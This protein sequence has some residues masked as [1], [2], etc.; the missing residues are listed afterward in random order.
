VGVITQTKTHSHS[1]FW[2]VLLMIDQY[3]LSVLC[4]LFL[5]RKWIKLKHIYSVLCVFVPIVAP[6]IYHF[7]QKHG[8][9]TPL[10]S[11]FH[12]WCTVQNWSSKLKRQKLGVQNR[13]ALSFELNL[14]MIS[15]VFM[16]LNVLANINAPMITPQTKTLLKIFSNSTL[17]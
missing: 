17:I 8:V 5:L 13:S 12:L 2:R 16:K 15:G 7:R 6:P 9:L 1:P 3:T 11:P 4:A 14:L 10:P